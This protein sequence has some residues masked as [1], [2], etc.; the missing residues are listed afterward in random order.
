V[1][2]LCYITFLYEQVDAPLP[3]A[4]CRRRQCTEDEY[5]ARRIHIDDSSGCLLTGVK[6]PGGLD[7]LAKYQ[8]DKSYAI[9]STSTITTSK[10]GAAALVLSPPEDQTW[11]T[12]G[13]V[14]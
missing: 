2:A 8:P 13:T 12:V 10:E 5:G 11:Q 6:Q 3:R 7:W 1:P 14:A 9:C 4:F